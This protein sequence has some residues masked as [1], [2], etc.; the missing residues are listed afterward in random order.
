M[1]DFTAS[2]DLKNLSTNNFVVKVMLIFGCANRNTKYFVDT[3][4]T[5]QIGYWKRRQPYKNKQ[6]NLAVRRLCKVARKAYLL[7]F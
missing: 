4:F 5:A 3:A 1:L 2:S 6:Q 7:F